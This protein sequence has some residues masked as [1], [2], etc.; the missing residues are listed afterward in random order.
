MVEKI[1]NRRIKKKLKDYLFSNI[2]IVSLV[3]QIIEIKIKELI[4][5]RYIK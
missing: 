3:Y 5:L 4:V 1:I 2:I